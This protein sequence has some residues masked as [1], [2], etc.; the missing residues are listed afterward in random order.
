MKNHIVLILA[1]IN[2][3]T[4][5]SQDET[6]KKV[7]K[8]IEIL[9]NKGV[10]NIIA[11]S[12][13]SNESVIIWKEK[14]KEKALKIYRKDSGCIKMKKERLN[15]KEK[16]DFNDCLDNYKYIE[17][18]KDINCDEKVHAFTEITVNGLVNG[19]SFLHKFY[20]HCG[21]EKQKKKIKSFM[22]LYYNLL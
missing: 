11:I 15:R 9:K 18:I 21:T 2:S 20:S 6:S 16:E 7:I 1:I 13:E 4:M 12:N 10:E 22:S 5:F 3:F 14:G 8:Q 19:E 17:E